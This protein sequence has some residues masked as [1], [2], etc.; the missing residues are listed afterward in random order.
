MHVRH[1][2]IGAA[3]LAGTMA[4]FGGQ[5][6]TGHAAA[7]GGEATLRPTNSTNTGFAGYV[8]APTGISAASA[9][10][11][12]P[13]IT[14]PNS[15]G[16]YGV[17]PG[18]F[19]SGT[20]VFTGG[21]V[22]AACSAG[23]VSYTVAIILNGTETK[24]FA[25]TPGDTYSVSVSETTTAS[26]VTVKDVTHVASKTST[27]AGGAVT[28]TQLGD[29]SIDFNGVQGGVP[30]FTSNAFKAGK[31]DAGTVGAA[32]PTAFNMVNSSNVVLIL[33]GALNTT[34]NGWKETFKHN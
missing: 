31:I 29:D 1:T 17:A 12:L 34:G 24:S 6:L 27:G 28:Q 16:N 15:T 9:K 19:L 22:E 30:T 8:A 11:V 26:K 5:Q 2:L 18:V 14:C 23:V 25:G 7:L 3:L 10:F 4:A 20:S 21:G 33:T 13:T 32:S